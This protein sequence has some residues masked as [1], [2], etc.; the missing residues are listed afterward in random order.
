M[1]SLLLFILIIYI[2]RLI[3]IRNY[4]R[5]QRYAFRKASESFNRRAN[6][7][8]RNAQEASKQK[9]KNKSVVKDKPKDT[10]MVIREA[11]YDAKDAEYAEYED[12]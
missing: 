8:M 3:F 10:V 1:F 11:N 7:T 12:V 6:E 5:I 2:I 9:K 4:A